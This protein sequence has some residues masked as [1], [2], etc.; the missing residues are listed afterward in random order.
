[1][2]DRDTDRAS[3]RAVIDTACSRSPLRLTADDFDRAEQRR[4]MSS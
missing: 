3:V 1:V 4:A 2:S